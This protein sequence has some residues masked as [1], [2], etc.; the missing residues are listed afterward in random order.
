M[1]RCGG[2]GH[3]SVGGGRPGRGDPAPVDTTAVGAAAA[4][5]TAAAVGAAWGFRPPRP[6]WLAGLTLLLLPVAT[7]SAVGGSAPVLAVILLLLAAGEVVPSLSSGG[8]SEDRIGQLQGDESEA[9]ETGQE[10]IWAQAGLVLL[11]A[12][13]LVAAIASGRGGNGEWRFVADGGVAAGFGLAAAAVLLGAAALGPTRAVPMPYRASSS[14]WSWRRVCPRWRW[15]SSVGPS[16][17]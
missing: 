12:G 9:E 15:R 3:R 17:S 7:A 13:L 1:G 10:E 8:G 4:A 2:R 5:G 6:L 16:P 11:A 14:D